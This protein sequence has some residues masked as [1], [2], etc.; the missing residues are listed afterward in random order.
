M[1]NRNEW[2]ALFEAKVGNVSL[3]AYQ[4]VRYAEDAKANSMNVV[5][6]I[7]DESNH[8]VEQGPIE[9]PKRLLTKVKPL[10]L[11]K[12][13]VLSTSILMRK[14]TEVDGREKFFVL[15]GLI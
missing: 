12:R 9:I 10:H 4:V 14:R 1:K 5:I 15:D 13:L 3:S 2:T 8:R 7:L 11:S 6:T